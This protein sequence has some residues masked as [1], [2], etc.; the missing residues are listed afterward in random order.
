MT[1]EVSADQREQVDAVIE[2]LVDRL[3]RVVGVLDDHYLGNGA[4]QQLARV[5]LDRDLNR[6]D[7]ASGALYAEHFSRK[8]CDV[9]LRLMRVP[10]RRYIG[11]R[12]R[13]FMADCA[14]Y[15]AVPAGDGIAARPRIGLL[16]VSSGENALILDQ[17]DTYAVVAR[18]V[19][20]DARDDEFGRVHQ[21]LVPIVA[22]HA[23][24]PLG[25]VTADRQRRVDQQIEPVHRLFDSR[26]T[27][28][29]DGAGVAPAGEDAL[30]GIGDG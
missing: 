21:V 19:S 17:D 5:I 24:L 11:E 23:V 22:D 16:H 14:D 3:R 4:L 18:L 10:P 20:P 26:A 12:R 27:L 9:H 7:V 25:G 13:P 30:H 2:I 15:A 1:L 28:R 6:G 8:A 29:P